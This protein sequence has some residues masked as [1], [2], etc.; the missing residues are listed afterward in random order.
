MVLG[1]TPYG[2]TGRE[3]TEVSLSLDRDG[4][5]LASG[6]GATALGSPVRAVTLLARECARFGRPLAAGD[7]VLSGA[8]TPPVAFDVP[9][10][11]RAELSGLG[12]TEVRLRTET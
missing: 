9:G 6:T 12:H 3:L 10:R 1:T 2:L 7:V 4:T 5:P 11:Y 8:L